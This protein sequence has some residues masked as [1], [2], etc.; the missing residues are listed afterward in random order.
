M[1]DSMIYYYIRKDFR[2]YVVG[3]TLTCC[4]LAV[5]R[6]GGIGKGRRL[7]WPRIPE[8][9]RR[10]HALSKAWGTVVMGR[11]TYDALPLS[12]RPLSNRR[13]IVVGS[14]DNCRLHD[15]RDRLQN[16]LLGPRV[17]VVGGAQV[18]AALQ[19]QV[20]IL[21]L[22]RVMD[23]Y[24]DANVHVDLPGLLR[25]FPVIVWESCL[26]T[27]PGT[28]TRYYFEARVRNDLKGVVS[29]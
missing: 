23:V 17:A 8:D 18:L 4:I 25:D 9:I 26:R 22:T 20:D 14:G 10:F 1:S 28:G 19:D 5:D 24:P 2:A 15:V 12:V 13:N 16:G 3:M 21:Y 27:S 7:P 11:K 6:R 29:H